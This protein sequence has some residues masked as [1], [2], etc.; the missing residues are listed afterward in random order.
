MNKS[1]QWCVVLAMAACAVVTMT[2]AAWAELVWR[3]GRWVDDRRSQGFDPDI[4]SGLA[5]LTMIAG[6]TLCGFMIGWFFSPEAKDVRRALALAFLALAGVIVLINDGAAGWG[7]ATLFAMLGF[8]WGIGYWLGQAAKSLMVPPTTFG[9]AKWAEIAHLIMKNLIGSDG[10]IL[11]RV[12]DGLEEKLISYKGDRH[13]LT[14]A[15]TRSWK[16][17]SHIIPNLLNTTASVM[18]ID[19]K[20][21][22]Y[23]ITAQH[24]ANMGQ[25]VL[26]FDPWDIGASKLGFSPA[27]INP[28]DM[29]ALSDI[30]AP[31]NAMLLADALVPGDSGK[32]DPFWSEEAK[33]FIQGLLLLI[34][35]D[36]T[37]EGRRNLGTLRDLLLLSGEDLTAL[38]TYMANSPHALIASAGSRALQKEPKLLANVLA[39][40]QAETHAL[41]S[42]RVR[43]ALSVSDFDFADLKK[44][45]MSIYIIMPADRLNAFSRVLRLIVQQAI[46]VNAR[47]IED[48]PDKPVLFILDEMPAL[49]RLKMV[50]EAYGLMAGF[51]IQLWGITQDLCQLRRVYGDDYESF[52]AN[53]GVVSYF[54]SPDKTSAEYFSAMCGETTVWNF[55]TAVATAFT[56]GSSNA[57]SNTSSTDTNTDTRAAS[58]RKLAYPDEL[59]RLPLDKQIILIENANPIMAEKIKWFDDPMFKDKGVNTHKPSQEPEDMAVAEEVVEYFAA[60]DDPEPRS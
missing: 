40:A 58:Q 3:N 21:E 53:S 30:D 22:N 31:E 9:S 38:F 7:L 33:G 55:S 1:T 29:L 20:A 17:V 41:D 59:R 19:P 51:G 47:N 36:E 60:I 14:V 49:G 24:R 45:P 15:P 37:Y 4:L 39:S 12:F 32:A 48:K 56:S 8:A 18:V 27:R 35:F 25:Q 11:G 16:G 28:L 44:K 5:R 23:L 43:E 10:I 13:L 2:D 26:A 6:S 46:T 42:P 34:A 52:I 50:E 54:G 57:G